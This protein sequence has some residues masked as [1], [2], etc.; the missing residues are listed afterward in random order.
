[1][2]LSSAKEPHEIVLLVSHAPHVV[3][4]MT[5]QQ[6]L[7]THVPG[8]DPDPGWHAVSGK[9]S[10]VCVHATALLV[11][12]PNSPHVEGGTSTQHVAAVQSPA[13]ALGPG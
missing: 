13:P 9:K 12:F 3:G 10:C 8:L 1:M 2:A 6:L 5:L 7:E 11:P 4:G